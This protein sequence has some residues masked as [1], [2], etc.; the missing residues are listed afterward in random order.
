MCG[1][2]LPPVFPGGVEDDDLGTKLAFH[3]FDRGHIH[4]A[5]GRAGRSTG[6]CR[7]TGL[8]FSAEASPRKFHGV[9][10]QSA[11][12]FGQLPFPAPSMT[13][14]PSAE[15]LTGSPLELYLRI[16]VPRRRSGSPAGSIPISCAPLTGRSIFLMNRCVVAAPAICGGGGASATAPG[17]TR[18]GSAVSHSSPSLRSLYSSPFL[19]LAPY[20]A[21]S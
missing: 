1:V 3:F 5:G 9:W 16:A 17:Q 18:P 15:K 12:V 7:Q 19:A 14:V 2:D 8:K 20:G 11:G 4:V 13:L 10:S 21:S 6:A